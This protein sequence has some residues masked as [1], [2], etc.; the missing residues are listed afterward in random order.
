MNRDKMQNQVCQVCKKKS[1]ILT[2]CKC[3]GRISCLKHRFH[4]CDELKKQDRE[5]LKSSLQ[6][7]NPDKVEKI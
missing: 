4:Y 7:I 3:C 5:Q 2:D 6:S 1:L